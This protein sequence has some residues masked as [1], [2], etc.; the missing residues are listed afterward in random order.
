[1]KGADSDVYRNQGKS[2]WGPQRWHSQPRPACPQWHTLTS[3][4]PSRSPIR[5][6]VPMT[7]ALVTPPTRPATTAE[8]PLG[9]TRT[10]APRT[11][12][13]PARVLPVPT[14]PARMQRFP[15]FQALMPLPTRRVATR[16]FR[17]AS[18]GSAPLT[19]LPRRRRSSPKLSRWLSFPAGC[20][21]R[22]A[23]LPKTPLRRVS[24]VCRTRRREVSART[25]LRRSRSA[26]EAADSTKLRRSRGSSPVAP[27]VPGVCIPAGTR[28]I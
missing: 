4:C 3:G 5:A 19:R 26:A 14:P 7:P 27:V 24:S 1:M 20:V 22:T 11:R 17:T 10:R 18:G 8:R 2:P 6:A 23:G 16:S 28:T 25:A 21:R 13:L 15:T 9:P 12:V